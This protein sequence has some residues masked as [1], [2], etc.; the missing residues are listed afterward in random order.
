[1]LG[2]VSAACIGPVRVTPPPNDLETMAAV[3]TSVMET[4]VAGG[5][6]TTTP[7]PEATAPEGIELTMAVVRSAVA[8][9]VAVTTP[10]PGCIVRRN[11]ATVAATAEPT[12][13][14]VLG[15]AIA[16]N[17]IECTPGAPTPTLPA[18]Q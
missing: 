5:T 9:T 16:G 3:G 1:M 10:K 15:T 8:G 12:L 4:M 18:S 17:T 7:E 11:L 2:L 6:P 13:R 14:A